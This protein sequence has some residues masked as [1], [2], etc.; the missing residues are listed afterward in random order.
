MLTYRQTAGHGAV[1]RAIGASAAAVPG[2]TILG[3]PVQ[4]I[5]MATS[6]VL[7]SDMETALDFVWLE[8]FI[9]FLLDI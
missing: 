4:P 8:H 7:A 9:D 2:L 5:V 6:P 3:P 1:T